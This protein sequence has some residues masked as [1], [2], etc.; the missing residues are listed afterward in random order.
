MKNIFFSQNMKNI[1]LFGIIFGIFGKSEI[2]P[3]YLKIKTRYPLFQNLTPVL[4]SL[5]PGKGEAVRSYDF[6]ANR[7]MGKLR[8]P[9]HE[10]V[11]TPEEL[12]FLEDLYSKYDRA[13]LPASWDSRSKGN[14]VFAL[15]MVLMY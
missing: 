7:H 8:T 2:E 6:T 14:Y 9:E 4:K 3:S 13:A 1:I 5:L 12:A 11:N 15:Y 10:K